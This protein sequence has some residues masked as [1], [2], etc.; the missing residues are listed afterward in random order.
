MASSSVSHDPAAILA[1]VEEYFDALPATRRRKRIQPDDTPELENY[2]PTDAAPEH[3]PAALAEFKSLLR[4]LG[5]THSAYVAHLITLKIYKL[6]DL[7]PEG[8]E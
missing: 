6:L 5:E 4:Q 8:G 3:D 7:E 1:S 2:A